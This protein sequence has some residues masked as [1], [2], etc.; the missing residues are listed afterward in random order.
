MKIGFLYAGQ[1][2][3]KAGMGKDLYEAYP[4]FVQAIDAIDAGNP[5]I[6]IKK[7]LFDTPDEE[8]GQTKNTQPA[9]AAFAAGVT[10]VLYENGIRPAYAAGLSLGEYS[11]LHAAGVWDAPTL[12]KLT[13]FRGAKM[14]EA[15]EA[16]DGAMCAIIG[17][18]SDE[19]AALCKEVAE[20]TGKFVQAANF[21][22]KTQTVVGGERAAVEAT[23]EKAKEAGA[24]KCSMLAVS[25]AFHTEFM[26]PASVALKEY[27][28]DLTFGEM[29]FPI[30]H[31]T[32]ARPLDG[33]TLPE[34]LVRQ[35]K[36]PVRMWESIEY[37]AA[38]GVDTIIEVG[39]GKVL[40]GFVR[41]TVKG[42]KTYVIND[43]DGMAK[44]L[45]ALAG[46]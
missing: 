29:Q 6:D 18:E 4:A 5:Q 20:S 10:A 28:K 1:G 16:V 44:V 36:S 8:L 33:E 26:E 42:V 35:V 19:V 11:A 22:T 14:Q 21:N 34:I 24:K 15:A 25:S 3:Q 27:F 31:N 30:I 39:P 40:S 32:T 41:K 12:V 17:P 23:A 7:L 43:A 45:E 9:L 46:Q 2:S 13:A 37:M 38:Q